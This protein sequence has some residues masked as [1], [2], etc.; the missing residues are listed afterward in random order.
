MRNVNKDNITQTVLD[1]IAN[2]ADP[3]TKQIMQAL[4]R[5]LHA[6][7]REVQLTEGELMQGIEFL[8][9]TGQKCTETRQ[10]FILLSDV[11]GLSMLTVTLNNDK[12]AAC[13][14]ATVF[15]PFFVLNAPHFENGEDVANGAPGAPCDVRCTVRGLNGE[16][17]AGAQVD[18]WQADDEGT[19]DVQKEG[20]EHAQARGTLISQTDGS[21]HFRSIVPEA[22][23]IPTDGP[24]GTLLEA[25][26]RHLWRPA[27]LHFMIQAPGYETLVTHIFRDG[28]RYLD[29]D[30][31]F[32]VRQSLVKAID[33][34]ADGSYLMN[35]DFVLNP[36]VA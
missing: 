21:F 31:V 7:A 8:T 33:Q 28:D 34:Q 13:T 35:Y 11:L 25:T 2:T 29:S 32:G 26:G 1:S 27:H 16:P 4:I 6:F 15:G 9:A 19:Y 24:V 20:L 5:H 18:V 3:R 14:E 17:I 12:P 22:Y 30:A 23:P 36:K 10:E